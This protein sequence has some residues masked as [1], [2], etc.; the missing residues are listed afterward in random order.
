M[1]N[2][3]LKKL[4]LLLSVAMLAIVSSVHAEDAKFGSYECKIENASINLCPPEHW[5]EIL[6]KDALL[7]HRLTNGYPSSVR[8][9]AYFVPL[10][11]WEDFQKQKTIGF[12][13]YFIFQ[14][15]RN[16]SPDGLAGFKDYIK[17]KQGNMPDHSDLPRMYKLQGHVS[18][19]V[20]DETDDSISFENLVKLEFVPLKEPIDMVAANSAI[21]MN[22]FVFSVYFYQSY[23]DDKDVEAVKKLTHDWVRAVEAKNKPKPK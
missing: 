8:T 10:S 14:L 13:H 7:A 12:K 16:M 18:L 3:T 5:V 20:F 9:L 11:E 19:G 4:R 2:N 21:R 1:K 17:T 6:S 15:A 22:K 23:H